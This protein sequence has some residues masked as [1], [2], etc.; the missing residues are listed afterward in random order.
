MPLRR[1]ILL[2]AC[3]F[4]LAAAGTPNEAAIALF[5][6]KQ[7][8]D[9]RAAFEKITTADPNNAEAHYYLGMIAKRR[10]DTDEAV[11]QL[12]QATSLAPT[13]S[14]YFL[15]LGDAYGSAAGKAGLFSKIGLAQKCQAAL[16][17]SVALDP[18]NLLARNGLV[19]YYREAPTFAGGGLSKAYEQAA[20]IKKRDPLMGA[21]VYGQLYLVEKKYDEAFRTFEDVLKTSPDNY[22]SLY[23]VGRTA[24]QTGL[25]LERGEQTLKRCLELPPGKGEPGHAAV[26]WRLGNIA[27][28]LGDPAGARAH[29]EAGLKDDPN[30]PQLTEALAKLK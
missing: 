28:K 23:S 7:Y 5:K 13:N 26:Q 12:E 29:Y 17:K 8:P 22:L 6:A 30:F 19:T 18:N 2:F 24:A 1:L 16:E 15:D 10:S 20:E 21:Q 14:E 11:R 9:A 27:E 3:T 25:R 4:A